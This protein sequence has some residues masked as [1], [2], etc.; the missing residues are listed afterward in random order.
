[1]RRGRH[2]LLNCRAKRKKLADSSSKSN[3]PCYTS[4]TCSQ[5]GYRQKMP[6]SLRVLDCPCCHAHLDRGLNASKNILALELQGLG[7]SLEAPGGFSP[8]TYT[9][10]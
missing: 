3:P 2:S 10:L 7:L 4:Q 5:C 9:Q 6:L 1:M 8:V